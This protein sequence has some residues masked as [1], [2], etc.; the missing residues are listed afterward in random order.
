M[1]FQVAMWLP[2]FLTMCF[3]RVGNA[4]LPIDDCLGGYAFGFESANLRKNRRLQRR[5]SAFRLLVDPKGVYYRI[6][7]VP[8]ER[9]SKAADTSQKNQSATRNFSALQRKGR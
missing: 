7:I 2:M 8:A 6:S 4:P 3:D 1:T 5:K 9:V